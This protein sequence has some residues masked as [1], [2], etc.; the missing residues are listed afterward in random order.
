MSV[1]DYGDPRPV[2]VQI[3]ED[4]RKRIE[5]GEYPVGGKL[6]AIRELAGA[7]HVVPGTVRDALDLLRQDKVVQTRSTRGT[8]VLEPEAVKKTQDPEALA[9][10]VG[11]LYGEV[12]NLAQQV[13]GMQIGEIREAL[14]RLEAEVADLKGQVA[15][16]RN[17]ISAEAGWGRP[18]SKDKHHGDGKPN[19]NR[20][21][22]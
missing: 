11:D 7:Y 2:K 14:A 20:N 16:V 6:P 21:L 4:L 19:G 9:Q 13:E 17:D 5:A 22:A 8:Y 18:G 1:P 15:S 12:H 3:A 10:Q